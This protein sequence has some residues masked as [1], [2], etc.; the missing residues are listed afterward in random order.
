MSQLAQKSGY[1][2]HIDIQVC[3]HLLRGT[4]TLPGARK[5]VHDTAMATYPLRPPT[6]WIGKSKIRQEDTG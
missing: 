3:K 2:R 4:G 6:S 1:M 5:N